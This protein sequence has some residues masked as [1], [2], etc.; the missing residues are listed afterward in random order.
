MYCIC[1]NIA[2]VDIYMQMYELYD[3]KYVIKQILTHRNLYKQSWIMSVKD[4]KVKLP[5][6]AVERGI[7][8]EQIDFKE[9][10]TR[11]RVRQSINEMTESVRGNRFGGKS[12]QKDE[13]NL[14]L[15]EY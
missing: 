4:R 15:A 5:G 2:S 6:N 11:Y 9:G 8:W 1:V 13:E 10:I 7:H 3:I 14:L 12:K